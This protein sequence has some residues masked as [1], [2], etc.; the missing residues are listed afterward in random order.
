MAVENEIKKVRKISIPEDSRFLKT[1]KHM[2]LASPLSPLSTWQFDAQ[3]GV[4]AVSISQDGQRVLAGTLGKTAVCLDGSGQLLWQQPVGNQA[5]RVGLSRDGETAVTGTG[6]TRFWDMKGRGLTC[7]NSD[8]SLRWQQDLEASIWGLA[9]SA[10]GHTIV[11]GTSARQLLLFDEE[12]HLLW[13]QDVPGVGWY[14]WVWS[15]A[16]SADG[17]VIAAGAADK[18]IRILQRN[19][20]LLAEHRT[21]ADVF[22]TAVSANGNVIGAGDSSG[23]VYCLD[24]NGHLLWEEAVADKVWGVALSA[25][26]H[27]LLVGA[28]EKEAHIR[29]YNRAGQFLWKRHVG[30]T[31]TNVGLSADGRRI[32]AG[33]RDGGIFIFDEDQVLHQARAK[34]IVRDVAIST[35]GEWAVAGSEDGVAYG[36]HLPAIPSSE[37]SVAP[38]DSKYYINITG[39]QGIVIGDQV[40]VTQQ[41]GKQDDPDAT[42]SESIEVRYA[43]YLKRLYGNVPLGGIAPR[44]QD[45]TLNIPLEELFVP[46]QAEQDAP[47]R[48]QFVVSGVRSF[49]MKR[50]RPANLVRLD[51]IFENV[52]TVILGEPGSG[53]ST[54]LRWRVAQA[55]ADD[56]TPSPGTLPIFLRLVH[57]A[58][59]LEHEPGLHLAQYL[60]HR[61]NPKF[62]SLFDTMLAS[63]QGL[64]LLDGLDEVADAYLRRRVRDAIETFAVQFP[65][66]QV[67][68]TSRVTGYRSAQLSAIFNHFTLQPFGRKEIARFLRNWYRAVYRQTE[69]VSDIAKADWRVSQLLERLGS[70]PKVLQLAGTP[71]LLAIIA[72]MDWKGKEIPKRRVELYEAATETLLEDWPAEQ[73]RP[74]LNDLNF[75]EML[76][77]LAPLAYHMFAHGFMGAIHLAELEAQ[78]PPLIQQARQ[79]SETEARDLMRDWLP[80]LSEQSGLLLDTGVDEYHRPVYAFLHLTFVEYLSARA[81]AEQWRRKQV[82]LALYVNDPRWREVVLLMVGHIGMD[83][84]DEATHLVEKI[85]GLKPPHQDILHQALVLAAASLADDVQVTADLRAKIIDRLIPLWRNS[86]SGLLRSKL[87]RIL[88]AMHATDNVKLVVER[89]LLLVNDKETWVR[90]SVLELLSKLGSSTD[91]VIKGIL[92]DALQDPQSE[93]QRAAVRAIETL[94]LARDPQVRDELLSILR[95]SDAGVR[96]RTVLALGTDVEQD[97]WVIPALLQVQSEDERA[98]TRQMATRVLAMTKQP[99]EEVIA[100]MLSALDDDNTGVRKEAAAALLGWG[101]NVRQQLITALHQ[102]LQK[103]D[104]QKRRHTLDIVADISPVIGQPAIDFLFEVAQ[105]EKDVWVRGR[106]IHALGKVPNTNQQVIEVLTAA[107]PDTNRVVR[108][109]AA[110]GLKRIGVRSESVSTALLTALQTQDTQLRRY[111]ADALARCGQQNTTTFSLLEAALSDTDELVCLNVAVALLRLGAQSTIAQQTLVASLQSKNIEVRRRAA[112]E[113]SSIIHRV[114]PSVIDT[115][116]QLVTNDDQNV[117]EHALLALAGL[118]HQAPSKVIR[119]SCQAL[120]DEFHWT[121]MRA[122]E[123]LGKLGQADEVTVNAL[124][125]ALTDANARVRLAASDALI[126]LGEG[127]EREEIIYSVR[128]LFDEHSHVE[129]VLNTLWGLVVG[130]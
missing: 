33:T 41:F 28:G 73:G 115:L 119:A 111:A 69:A 104:K 92:L 14:A 11:A 102:A 55:V 18:R 53:K 52:H 89:M 81:L 10:D 60:R 24:R 127:P 68:V 79:C 38:V 120:S 76:Q 107:L 46:L 21:R 116:I 99:E 62:Q 72:L 19:G 109:G 113:L 118:G 39:S 123:A 87:F 130:E 106:A 4:A 114:D 121:R 23:Y 58:A 129:D 3:S 50:S 7:F 61:H 43:A 84:V 112:Q 70:K 20:N 77:V 71:L 1:T 124:L 49:Q 40:Q 96:S 78:I 101:E 22:A 30:G 2:S 95:H 35:T 98:D 94:A 122:A 57:F 17:L 32:V 117:Q 65:D 45:R 108:H 13:R 9:V 29:L 59:V 66:F 6:S 85:C 105:T 80:V 86:T 48:N 110:L 37:E 27:R 74:R 51:E 88:A 15:A 126:A 34:K 63:G 103:P 26:G 25:D 31:V 54:L 67:A 64:L 44:V 125:K 5:W 12:G 47:L 97:E 83:S 91:V 75:Q 82:D 56:N 100:G 128:A 90:S 93:V 36:F 16:L 42:P 8:G